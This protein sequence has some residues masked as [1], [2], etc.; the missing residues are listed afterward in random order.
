MQ[1]FDVYKS[2][3]KSYP[4]LVDV[5]NDLLS[6]LKSRVVIPM[7]PIDTLNNNAKNLCPIIDINNS[8]FILLTHQITSIPVSS[9]KNKVSSLKCCRYEILG[10]ID[11][12]LTGI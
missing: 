2:D 12:L 8:D 9:L 11:L 10:A 6:G 4:Y 7:S 5:Q 3:N 1:Q